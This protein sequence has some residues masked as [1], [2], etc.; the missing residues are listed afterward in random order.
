MYNQDLKKLGRSFRKGGKFASTNWKWM[1]LIIF[2]IYHLEGHSYWSTSCNHRIY[3]LVPTTKRELATKSL[4]D[5]SGLL[6]HSNKEFE[7]Y[8]YCFSNFPY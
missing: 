7:I 5:D 8:I 2:L 3:I 6:D 4:Q 1:S